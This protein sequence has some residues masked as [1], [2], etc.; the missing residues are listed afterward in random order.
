MTGNLRR[1]MIKVLALFWVISTVVVL[2]FSFYVTRGPCN[3]TTVLFIIEIST[4]FSTLYNKVITVTLIDIRLSY[5]YTGSPIE[6]YN[7]EQSVS[8]IDGR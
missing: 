8:K 3:C 7:G 2:L 5:T 1:Q 6:Q 4:T